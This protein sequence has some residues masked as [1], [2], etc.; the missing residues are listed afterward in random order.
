[1]YNIKNGTKN[2]LY[3]ESYLLNDHYFFGS[4]WCNYEESYNYYNID[5]NN[6]L[7]NNESGNEYVI[8]Y[9][10]KYRAAIAPL[11]IKIKNFLDNIPKLENG[12]EKYMA[13]IVDKNLVSID[14]MQFM[15]LVKNLSDQQLH[16]CK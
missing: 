2:K 10:D 4:K 6:I 1:M 16:H 11:Q 14:S 5:V 8:R 3:D 13:F 12:L 15:N 7:P 9:I